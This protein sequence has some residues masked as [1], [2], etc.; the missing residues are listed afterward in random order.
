MAFGQIASLCITDNGF[1]MIVSTESGEIMS[2]DLKEAIKER[3][4]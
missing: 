3:A 1:T 2:Y 4:D